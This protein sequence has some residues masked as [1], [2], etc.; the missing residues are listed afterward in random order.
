MV[1][2]RIPRFAY[3]LLLAL[4]C[5]L[6]IPSCKKTV[7]IQ[8]VGAWQDKYDV[9]IKEILRIGSDDQVDDRYAFGAINE[10]KIDRS[11]NVYVLDRKENRI[12]K[13]DPNGQYVKSFSFIK[14]QGPG[15]IQR[16]LSFDLGSEG[17]LFVIDDAQN[18]IVRFSGEGRYQDSQSLRIRHSD[19]IAGNDD[20]LYLIGGGQ[21]AEG[22]LIFAYRFL[23]EKPIFNFC[24]GDQNSWLLSR[25]GYDGA[26]TKDKNG[27]IFYSFTYPNEIRAFSPDGKMIREFAREFRALKPIANSS[28][29]LPRAEAVVQAV[30][31]F[32]DGK[33]LNVIFDR[34]IKPYKFFFDFFDQRG[35]WLL[36]F[37]S[38]DHLKEW[39]G[40]IVRMDRQG[41]FYLEYHQ[42]FPHVRKYS[43]QFVK[44]NGN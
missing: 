39:M 20:V 2:A 34:R 27:N 33:V 23:E 3:F 30:C 40:R 32:P 43:I 21:G 22:P 31:V 14:G 6:W 10:I 7:S 25:V 41:N 12:Q 29:E 5:F 9:F 19:L 1:N 16:P 44:K 36:S 28:S 11:D 17:Q 26:V 4:S 37:D 13:Y 38:T 18:K 8:R 42:P 15:E 35:A 24:R